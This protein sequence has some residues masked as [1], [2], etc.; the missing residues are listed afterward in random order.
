MLERIYRIDKLL[1]DRRFVTRKELETKLGISWAT[2]K[3]DLSYMRDRLHAPIIFDRELGGYRFETTEK[4]LGPQYELPGFWFS[5]EEIHALLTMQH[6]ISNLDP[7]GLLGPH[8]EPLLSRLA[9][10]LG[11]AAD[12]ADEITRRIRIETV[13]ARRFHLDHFQLLGASLLRRKRLQIRYH[14]RSSDEITDREIS[15]QR[16]VYYRDNWY[17]DS[18]CH[19]R[20]SLRAFAV[21]SIHAVDSLDTPAIEVDQAHLDSE[22]GS[23]YG[24]FSGSEVSWAALRFTPERGRWVSAEQWHPHQEGNTLEDGTYEKK[25]P[26]TDD[27]EILMDILKYGRDCKVLSPPELVARVEEQLKYALGQYS[28]PEG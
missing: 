28:A 23:G 21:D 12:S 7:G 9:G 6:L 4:R 15:P 13:G 5:A 10:I 22:L 2:L 19:L 18:W 11:T 24:I 25:V 14:A 17:L 3:R 1:A 20:E 8:I 26:Y 27:R 16:L